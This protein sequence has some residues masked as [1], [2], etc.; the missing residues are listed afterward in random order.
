MS[1]ELLR[2]YER[3]LVVAWGQ[4]PSMPSAY[5]RMTSMRFSCRKELDCLHFL[6]SRVDISAL[7]MVNGRRRIHDSMNELQPTISQLRQLACGRRAAV[8][9]AERIHSMAFTA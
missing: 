1:S 4:M 6:W 7:F 5:V 8:C 2:R 9:V 3:L